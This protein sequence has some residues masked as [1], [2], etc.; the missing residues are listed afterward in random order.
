MIKRY[1][2]PEIG[3]VWE[4]QN[5]YQKILDVELAVCE[6]QSDWGHIPKEVVADIKNNARFDLVRVAEIEKEVNHDVIALLTN[7]GEYV[8]EYSRYIHVGLTSYDV[9][10]TALSLMVKEAG[11]LIKKKLVELIEVLINQAK[12]HKYTVMMGRTHG[13]HAEPI[14]FGLKMALWVEE[15]RRNL[16]RLEEAISQISYGKLSGAVGTYAHLGPEVEEAVCKK[17]GLL[18]APISTQILQ[19]DRH[20]Q[21]LTTLA[22]L[23]SSL[24]KFCSELR[25]LQRTEVGEVQEPFGKG[26][27]G[28]SAM[29]HKRNPIICERISGLARIVRGNA[30]AGLENICLW[31][32]R[33]ITHS[34]V[35]RV[36]LPD[37]TILVH[38]MLH[39]FIECMQ[40]LVVFP[41][42]MKENLEDSGGLFFSQR[43]L[44]T[45]VQKGLLREEAYRLVQRNA[46]QAIDEKMPFKTLILQ[47]QDVSKY[48]DSSEIEE[49]FE[50]NYYL[51]KIDYIFKRVGIG[52]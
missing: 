41:Q 13:M 6:V 27:K 9:V 52:S 28:S 23:A 20:A 48:L 51:A 26:Q 39:K 3:R 47:D 49:C 16:Q 2:L 5:R 8:G 40:N 17:L 29:P 25:H 22:I 4:E 42:K 35:E 7:V 11:E 32:E 21:F 46:M 24:D 45:I 1:T 19:R 34:S 10:D 50:L 18:P 14:T 12:A 31:H 36:I 43:V 33:D 15:C 38:Y 37:S 30:I 44:L